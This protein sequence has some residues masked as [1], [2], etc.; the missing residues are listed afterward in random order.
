M[1]TLAISLRLIQA[2]CRQGSNAVL[3]GTEDFWQVASFGVRRR[4]AYRGSMIQGRW[5]LL[6]GKL[7][8]FAAAILH[9][10]R[11]PDPVA[12]LSR[13]LRA[14]FGDAVAGISPTHHFDL[15]APGSDPI[16]LAR[17]IFQADLAKLAASTPRETKAF[18]AH[19]VDRDFQEGRLVM[20]DGW[21]LAQTEARLLAFL[22]SDTR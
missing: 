20:I 9:R 1:G 14:L 7:S 5:R 10:I 19:V 17:L 12:I 11:Q 22:T 3:D 13:R 21:T 18:L 16:A 4:T 6:A 15:A 2:Y 8:V